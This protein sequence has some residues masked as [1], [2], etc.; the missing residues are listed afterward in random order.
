MYQSLEPTRHAAECAFDFTF[1]PIGAWSPQRHVIDFLLQLVLHVQGIVATR[2]LGPPP[3]CC[4]HIV[5]EDSHDK[6]EDA[7]R[8]KEKYKDVHHHEQQAK[9]FSQVHPM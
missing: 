5:D 3:A 4:K 6:V 9:L 7:N 8:H 1:F 2:H